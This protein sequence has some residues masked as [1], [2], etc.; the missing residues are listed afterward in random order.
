[1]LPATQANG[2]HGHLDE[3]YG[4]VQQSTWIGGNQDYSSLGEAGSYWLNGIVPLGFQLNDQRI[5][6]QVDYWVNYIINDQGSDGWIGPSTSPRTLWGRFPAMLALMQYAEANATAAPTVVNTM[7]KFTL[8]V[9]NMLMNGGQGWEEWGQARW[10]DLALVVEWLIDKHPNGQENT[11]LNL[12]KLLRYGGTNWKLWFING[13]FPTDAVNH[14]DIRAHGVNNGQALKS[15]AVA[16]R[17]SHDSSDLDSTRSRSSMIDQYHGR[18][19]GIFGCDEHL[20]GLMPSRGSEL[21]TVV[22]TMYSYEYMYTVAGDNSFADKIEQLAYNALPGTLT[23]DMWEHQYLQQSNQIWSKSQSPSVFATDGPGSYSNIFGLQPNYPCCTVNHG[24]GWPKFVS[25]AYMTS[26]DSSTIYHVLLS[27]TSV[28]T[29]LSGKNA[30]SV[31]ANTNYPFSSTISYSIKAN[32][33]FSFGVR[34]P[35]WVNGLISYSIDGGSALKK[36]TGKRS[37]SATPNS[38][39]YVIISVPGGSHTINVNIPM[40]IRTE[41]RYNGA[42]AVY[43]GPLTYSLNINYSTK[44]LNTYAQSSKD[45]EFDPTSTWQ[46]ALVTSSLKY[47]GDANSLPQTVWQSS[48]PPVSISANVCPITWN[49]VTNSAD[50][51]PNSPAT[52]TGGVT[53]V[54]LIPYGAA[55]LRITEM[56]TVQEMLPPY[57]HSVVEPALSEQVDIVEVCQ[58]ERRGHAKDKTIDWSKQFELTATNTWGIPLDRISRAGT[59][60]YGVVSVGVHA[61]IV[62]NANVFRRI[63]FMNGKKFLYGFMKTMWEFPLLA[64]HWRLKAPKEI[65]LGDREASGQPHYDITPVDDIEA[66][67]TLSYLLFSKISQLEPGFVICPC[68]DTDGMVDVMTAEFPPGTPS[69][70]HIQA[71]MGAVWKQEHIGMENVKY[72]KVSG[73]SIEFRSSSDQIVCVDGELYSTKAH[74]EIQVLS[75]ALW[76]ILL[77]LSLS[78]AKVEGYNRNPFDEEGLDIFADPPRPQRQPAATAELID[79]DGSFPAT[80]GHPNTSFQSSSIQHATGG[81]SDVSLVNEPGASYPRQTAKRMD[82]FGDMGSLY[83]ETPQVDEDDDRQLLANSAPMAGHFDLQSLENGRDDTIL[84][85]S[86]RPAKPAAAGAKFSLPGAGLFRGKSVRRGGKPSGHIGADSTRFIY[87]NNEAM[88]KEQQFLHNRVFTAKYTIITFLPKFL[89]EEFSKY[90]NLFFLFISAVQQVPGI[91]P[92]SRWTTLVPLVIVLALTAVKEIVEDFTIHRS[93]RELNARKVKVLEHG[94]FVTKAW[95]DVCVG[96]ILRVESGDSFAADLVLLSSS[97]P[98]GLCYIETSNLDGEVNLK[99]K[100][101]LPATAKILDPVAASS[102][103][104]ILKSELPNNRLYNFDGTLSL[105]TNDTGRTR[106]Y[107]LDP[108][109]LLLRGAMLRN[110][111]WIY[112]L[113]VF[114]GHET[115]LMLNSS[116]KPSKQSNVTRITN[117]NILNLFTILVVMSIACAIG[118]VVI[119]IK[120]GSQM[121]YLPLNEMNRGSEFGYDIL[122]FLI[123]FN[124]FIPISLMV[125]MELVKYA[126]SSLIDSDLDMY[127]D[128]TDTPATAR[129]SSLIEELG[130]VGYVFSD[131][132]GTLTCNQMEFKECSIA[133]LSYAA[134]V[135]AD[136]QAQPGDE[137]QGQYNFRQMQEHLKSHPTAN[138]INEFFTLLATCHTVIPERANGSDEII[139]QASSPDEGALVNGA[140]A[141]GYKFHTRRPNSINITVNGK[142][143]E[144]EILNICEFNST[145]KRMSAVIRGPDGRIKLYCK[146][147]DTVILERLA[148]NNPFVEQTLFHLE[149]FATEGLRTL[150]IAMREV[151]D[152]EYARW[153]QIYE[154]AATTLT[155]RAVEL[156]KAAEMIEQNLFLLGATAIEDKLQDGVPDTIHTLQEAGIK[157]WVLTGDRQET[158][159]NIGYSCKLLNDEMSLIVCNE[160]S[161][162]ET[163]SF[164]DKKLQDIETVLSRGDDMEP[165][166]LVIDGKALTF[167]LEK[168]IEKSFLDLAVKC[169]A[170]VC[171]RVSPL[172]KA[173][174]VKLVKKYVDSILLAIGDG[175][176]DVSMIQAA[177]VGVG[178]S[179]VE[180]L[181]AARSSDFA[182]SQFRFLRKLLL[183]HG[184]W[185]YQ[186]LSKMIFYYFYK[187]IALYLTQFWFAFFNGFSGQTLYESWTMSCFNVIFTFLPPLVIGIFDQYVSARMLDK[188]PQMYMLGQQNEFFNQKKFWGWFGNAIFHSLLLFFTGLLAFRDDQVFATGWTGGLWWVGTTVFSATLITILWK[189]VLITDV[190]TKYTF[191]AIPGSVVLWFIFLPVAVGIGSRWSVFTEYTGIIPRLWGNVNF[192]LYIILVPFMANLRDFAWKYAKRMYFPMSYH[193]VQEIQKYNIPDYRPRMDRFRQA[194]NKADGPHP[195]CPIAY[196]AEYIQAMG[197]F[198]ALSRANELSERALALTEHII[199]LN[200]AHYTIWLYRQNILFALKADFQKELDWIDE[201]AEEKSKNYQVWH[202][203]QVIVEKAKDPSREFAFINNILEEDAKNYHAWS[204]RQWLLQTFSLS[205]SDELQYTDDLIILDIRNNSAW[206]HRFFVLFQRPGGLAAWAKERQTTE[207]HALKEEISYVENKIKSAPNNQSSWYYMKGVLERTNTPITALKDFC[208][209]LFAA[210]AQSPH[211]LAAWVDIHEYLTL[212]DKSNAQ[213]VLDTCHILATQPLDPTAIVA[214]GM[215]FCSGSLPVVPGTG[216]VISENV[217]DQTR[218]SLNNLENV[219]DA[220]GSSLSEVVKTTVFLKDMNHFNEMNKVYSEFFPDQKPARSAVQVARLPK[221]VLVEIEAISLIKS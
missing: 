180:G 198:R 46:N 96:D 13:V 141:Q 216:H 59:S 69:R 146:G 38:A 28:S 132:T 110:T 6:G 186:R 62:F 55:K 79:L 197:Y 10:Q 112:G 107:A 99:I 54:N 87:I 14:V 160:E 91:S 145:R 40:S 121:T 163:K 53:S 42:T 8:L 213:T 173:L 157:V 202:H 142:D 203:R 44:V 164:L 133:G 76:V 106:D 217:A 221:D 18:S 52:C 195:L 45:L 50:A 17:F 167:A 156:D 92:T 56:P 128:V 1:M 165:L 93:D 200:P 205:W 11:Y 86:R 26:S 43:R 191:I 153:S 7:Q 114:T 29:T 135:D 73:A 97:E 90:A 129:S 144:Y 174:V 25:H 155:N 48:T 4:Y 138:V 19:S 140:S 27:P 72:R 166:A 172:Q 23:D 206:N 102:L 134:E 118:N 196:T 125:T 9:N 131:K 204:Y 84:P 34:V 103:R 61:H 89:Y 123:L 126:Q 30:V 177:H 137:G 130:Q 78:I 85:I 154:K 108:N 127:Y 212:Q 122:T 57:G 189:A 81:Y 162:W 151:S 70:S 184:S 15:E 36:N 111:S 100:Q 183:V 105:D 60:L 3:F 71:M 158:A 181:Q 188:Y 35:G 139:Y 176:N 12:L 22:E 124:S 83:D 159:I 115:K 68:A 80:N 88:N 64:I 47:N 63:P 37:T 171:C 207:D 208:T 16:Y 113:V 24:Q 143:L 58:T 170:V 136:R 98:E 194:V 210:H 219:L 220:S 82:S 67:S 49:V 148:E 187:N 161:H 33:G 95:R 77:S 209:Q 120:D 218:Q 199:H 74:L 41:K 65:S 119:S 215:V 109:Q 193:Y 150:C 66:D 185:A 147:A 51:P 178:I 39:G 169:K 5:L 190:W 192:W 31:T 21:C 168:D 175:A 152:E 182:I 101:A 149:E 104:G 116:K 214:N 201:I 211:L 179:G 75:K 20:A 94:Q 2:L 32:S 117:R